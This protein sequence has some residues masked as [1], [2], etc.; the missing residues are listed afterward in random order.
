MPGLILIAV[1]LAL[2]VLRLAVPTD[3]V[4]SWEESFKAVAHIF[5]GMMILR[6]VQRRGRWPL[7]WACLLVPSLLELA[8]F[9]AARA[10]ASSW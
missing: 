6:L 7:G 1:S 2:S 3:P 10:G 5:V 9:L 4:L 8:L